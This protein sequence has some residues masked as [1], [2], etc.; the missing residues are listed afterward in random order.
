MLYEVITLATPCP[1]TGTPPL[2]P[3]A[4]WI[5]LDQEEVGAVGAEQTASL[6]AHRVGHGQDQPVAAY[7]ADEREADA[8]VAAGRF[9][10]GISGP[11]ASSYNFV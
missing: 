8:G 7:C 5:V 10:D 2:L 4:E 6:D 3:G 9:D 1:D 11:D